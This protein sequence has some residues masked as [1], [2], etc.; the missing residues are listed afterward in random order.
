MRR[1]L[2]LLLCTAPAF[3]ADGLVAR[4][5]WELRAEIPRDSLQPLTD[6]KYG[7]GL[8]Y[9]CDL[10]G[11]PGYIRL[12]LDV[13]AFTGVKHQG[14]VEGMGAGVQVVYEFNEHLG[15]RPFVAAG[16][17]FEHWSIGRNNDVDP[18]APAPIRPPTWD[19]NKLAFRAE[20][21]C[22]VS[23]AVRCSVGALTGALGNGRSAT[24]LFLAVG[25]RM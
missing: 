9:M 8:G 10:G 12:R 23:Q 2:A 11:G 17:C 15:L 1:L 22:G 19:S 20:V 18:N 14:P 4:S 21:G 3:S 6:P 13:D 16:P 25:L 7:F 24:S 5:L